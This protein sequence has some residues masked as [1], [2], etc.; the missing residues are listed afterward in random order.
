VN[1]YGR[2]YGCP[3]HKRHELQLAPRL[4]RSSAQTV[5]AVG[6]KPEELNKIFASC[7]VAAG[8]SNPTV[9]ST[10]YSATATSVRLPQHPPPLAGV[11]EA[12]PVLRVDAVYVMPGAGAFLGL[13]IEIW[14]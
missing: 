9:W 5:I 4:R 14:P 7:Q 1:L 13:D 11:L 10:T 2:A 8:L 3:R 12:F 6:F